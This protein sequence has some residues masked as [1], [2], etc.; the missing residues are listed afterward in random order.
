MMKNHGS[1]LIIAL[2]AVSLS[3]VL[4]GGGGAALGQVE[5]F[6][7]PGVAWHT[8]KAFAE[9][10]TSTAHLAVGIS[11][12]DHSAHHLEVSVSLGQAAGLPEPEGEKFDLLVSGVKGPLDVVARPTGALSYGGSAFRTYSASF[13]V[14]KQ[15][16][17][18]PTQYSVL[19]DEHTFEIRNDR[20]YREFTADPKLPRTTFAGS[21]S[22]DVLLV[23]GDAVRIDPGR[24]LITFDAR[25]D[26]GG[27][28]DLTAILVLEGGAER[29][30]LTVRPTQSKD[31][32]ALSGGRY[33]YA[34][35]LHYQLSS[36]EKPKRLKLDLDGQSFEV[37]LPG[38][39]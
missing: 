26:S 37:E 8:T 32:L 18:E 19:F 15:K 6:S 25:R 9:T 1:A 23:G 13:L 22:G 4:P 11:V 3:M 7:I 39:D 33:A 28:A 21:Q 30:P 31:W 35:T 36:G 24:L 16:G 12:A 2:L 34:R 38:L 29:E 27:E 20:F 17:N 14:A 10:T 5:S